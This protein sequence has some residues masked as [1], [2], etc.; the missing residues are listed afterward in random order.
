MNINV[1]E[2]ISAEEKKAIRS[3]TAKSL[4]WLGVVSMVM[5]FAGL[6]S[7]YIVSKG[8]YPEKWFQFKFPVFFWI[9]TVVII[10]SSGT[11]F[12]AKKF[13]QKDKQS[14]FKIFMLVTLILGIAFC[15]TQYK[16]WGEMIEQGIYYSFSN[17]TSGQY[18]YFISFLHVIHV[19]AGILAVLV[20]TIKAL[21]GK[22]SS[23]N[24]L[25]ISVLSIFWHFL[26]ILWI[27]LCLFIYF[28]H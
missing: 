25:G 17:N 7:A 8:A 15:I 5:L 21:L 13:I 4:M 18:L 24:M 19:L 9:S 22:Y 14:E 1:S 12:L 2:N 11:L 27:Y 10:I 6:T 26:D 28:V 23:G 3:K 16:A 20:T